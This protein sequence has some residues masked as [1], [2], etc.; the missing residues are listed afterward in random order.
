[1]PQA[2]LLFPGIVGIFVALSRGV[3]IIRSSSRAAAALRFEIEIL[4][5]SFL[6]YFLS[7]YS[8]IILREWLRAL[9]TLIQAM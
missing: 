7:E 2:R 9:R 5:G 8:L 3:E 6:V 1:M 4:A